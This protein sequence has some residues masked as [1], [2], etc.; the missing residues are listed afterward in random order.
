MTTTFAQA[1]TFGVGTNIIAAEVGLGDN[2]LPGASGHHLPVI[3]LQYDRGLWNAGKGV[4]SLG[5]YAGY[6]D[7]SNHST[8]PPNA[9]VVDPYSVTFTTVGL[10]GA[11]HFAGWKVRNLDA[12]VGVKLAYESTVSGGYPN[13][14]PNTPA[15]QGIRFAPF[16]GA[17]YFFLPSVGALAEVGFNVYQYFDLGLAVKI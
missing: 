15:V 13:D 16:F 9:K 17:R 1:Q 3:D 10:R 2:V 6:G 14:L 4:I 8:P 7:Y 12:Y 11:Y 5:A